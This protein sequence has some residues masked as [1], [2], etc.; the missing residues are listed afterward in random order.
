MPP[1][2]VRIPPSPPRSTERC[3]SGLRSAT[4]NRVRAERC[5]AGSNPALSAPVSGLAHHPRRW[6]AVR[7]TVV[8]MRVPVSGKALVA[9]AAL[10]GLVNGA[11]GSLAAA[12]PAPRCATS[13]LV[14]WLD[15]RSGGAAA[16]SVYYALELTN[17][18]GHACTLCGYPGVSAVDL[19][20]RQLGSASSRDPAQA[21]R[22][23]RLA[24]GASAGAPLRIAG[25]AP[26][27]RPGG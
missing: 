17:L 6:C 21:P 23:V 24:H 3:P 20:G 13:G 27:P 22:S 14:I 15:T 1:S 16:G 12:S 11:D 5:V 10:C 26:Q 25:R 18:S 2:R 9:L 19:S 7:T 4:G 8:P